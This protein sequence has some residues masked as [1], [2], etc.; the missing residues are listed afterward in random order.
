[1]TKLH[2]LI[3]ALLCCIC[4]T[5]AAQDGVVKDVE[6]PSITYQGDLRDLLYAEPASLGP[7]KVRQ[8]AGP[9]GEI[10]NYEDR[11]TNM[12]QY[13]HDFINQYVEAG[14]TTLAG[15]NSWLNDPSLGTFAGGSYYYSLKVVTGSTGFTFPAGSSSDVIQQAAIDAYK[16]VYELEYDTLK[17]FLPYAFLSVNLD[18]PEFFW[19]GNAYQ[20][21]CSNSLSYSFSNSG[22]GTVN[23]T[24]THKFQLRTNSFDIR[25]SGINS[26]NFRIATNLSNA[27]Q[28]FN[29]SVQT[30]LSECQT[31]SRYDRLLAVHNWLTSHNCYN[32]FYPTYSQAQIGDTPWCAYSAIEG[33][34]SQQ[35]PVC[36][37][38][39][40]AFKVLCDNM[41]IPCILMSGQARFNPESASGAHM[42]N[43]VQMENGK[44]YA[45]DVTWDDPTVAGNYNVVSGYESQQWFLLGKD[46]DTGD[47]FPFIESHP[48]QWYDSFS[49][50]GSYPWELQ[51][52]PKL[53]LTAYTPGEEIPSYA[54]NFDTNGGSPIDSIVQ[55]LGSEITP[56]EQPTREGYTF[57]GWEPAIPAAMPEGGLT[58]VAQWQVNSYNLTYLVDGEV[59]K[60]LSVDYG[61][62]LTPEEEPTKEG[63]TFEGW[64]EIPETMPANDVV[65]T[66]SFSVNSYTLSYIVDG[67]V[68][69]TYEVEYGSTI[70]PEAE[71]TRDGYSFDGWSEI[72][73]TMPANDVVVTGSFTIK[74]ATEIVLDTKHL[75][76]N[77]VDAQKLTV[78]LTPADLINNFVFMYS[79]D[80]DI[81]T[82]DAEGM[83]TPVSNGEAFIVACT[84]DGSDL[85][86]SC[87]VTVDFKADTLSLD[88]TELIIMELN[89]QSLF[90]TIFPDKASPEVIWSS[91]DTTIV[92]VD[93]TGCITPRR[94]G[95]A[96]ITATTTDGTE[97]SAS[98]E[99]FVNIPNL[100][101]AIVTQTTLTVN[102]IEGVAEARNIK[103][104]LDGYEYDLSN[105][106]TI[107][108]LA[109]NRTYHITVNADIGEY[110]WT[111]EFDVTT[112]DIVVNF[113]CTSSPTTLD[114][115]ASYDAGD[116]IV[117]SAS[118]EWEEE[119]DT[120]SLSGLEPGET[121]EY[122][123]CITTEEGDV[124]IYKAQFTTDALAIRISE[125]KIVSAGNVVVV[126]TTN[127]VEEE[128]VNV[129]LEWRRYDW[130]EEI[131]TK[132]GVAYFLAGTIE[133]SIRNLNAEKF[134]KIRPVFLSQAGNQYVG[135][136]VTIDPSD[137]SFYAPIV[138][139]FSTDSIE[140]NTAEVK[141]LVLQGTDEVERQGFMYWKNVP[142]STGNAPKA[143]PA[144]AMIA[145]A[146]GE[147]MVATLKELEYETEYCYVAFVTTT[148]NE[149]F[150]GEEQ[151]FTTGEIDPD[152]INEV[153]SSK[154]K[155]QSSDDEWYDLSGRKIDK[156]TKGINIIRMRDGRTK[157][158]VIK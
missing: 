55:E 5:S 70:T 19:I 87:K 105:G 108:G 129:G 85:K 6:G 53:S 118:F 143:V 132:A 61:T 141:G 130:P 48:E 88:R 95:I 94:N 138:H 78:T 157:K 153:E 121:Y 156:P 147:M 7:S 66:S 26:Y 76:F 104:T 4:L 139:T 13:L 34:S 15:G 44:W 158:V 127:I 32:R 9:K 54:I 58:V 155:V 135:D 124:H 46:S 86:D 151:T 91:S 98:C 24:I 149:T 23:Y 69:K 131:Q 134:W 22:Q 148:G 83:V 112:A 77:S 122:T 2:S 52:G 150:Y 99:V 35:S 49:N 106:E 89:S 12:P 114:I 16:D 64:S 67:E 3:A 71:P 152:G 27:V 145:E 28:T 84:T 21:A 42:W 50:G 43:Y 62:P 146:S 110:N 142:A 107:T 1:M 30:I 56:P 111:E 113:A 65:V 51:A 115:S 154:F 92:T 37:G 103:V 31:G 57:I 45:V 14:R 102:C 90:A 120:L 93:E 73:E 38:Y 68:Y 36:E 59:Y 18:H 116:A 29:S 109:P 100:F 25:N 11:I 119:T 125:M 75:L 41:G 17:S 137:Y 133:G 47:G 63:Y 101:Q 144:N 136:W 10:V 82:V 97:L 117:T 60:T 128:N 80:S 96:T 33:N 126:A 72:P 39:A 74:L 79:T 8:A 40:R 20:L 81:A 140:G 123:Y